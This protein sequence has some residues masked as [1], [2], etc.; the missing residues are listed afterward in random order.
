MLEH[1]LPFK[2]HPLIEDPDLHYNFT[3]PFRDN[4]I[5]YAFDDGQIV[6]DGLYS[7]TSRPDLF[8][9]HRTKLEDFARISGFRAFYRDNLPYYQKQITLYRQKVPVRKMWTWLEKQFPARH[10]CYK[11]V[12]S[13]LIG[14]SHR[15]CGFQSNGFSETIMFVS[16]PGELEGTSDKVEE[17]CLSRV[18]FTEIDHN[19]VNPVTRAHADRVNKALDDLGQWNAQEN[20]RSAQMTFNEYMTW[21]V[22]A[23]Y[24]DDHYEET[25]AQII[26]ERST[27]ST[28]VQHRK[29]VRFREFTEQLRRLYRNRQPD[30]TIPDLYPA[31][32]VWME[33]Q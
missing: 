4:S 8:K 13:P 20:Y 25:N 10:D 1:F 21:A 9:R 7:Y 15:T 11:I 29:F 32:L 14:A 24:V 5:C 30:Q 3:Y 16:G 33:R 17:G 27:F 12:F 22:F 23:L 26:L 19:Y 18:V 6:H 2:D 28:M 31:I